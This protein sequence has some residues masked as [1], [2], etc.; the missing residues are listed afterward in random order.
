MFSNIFFLRFVFS[1]FSSSLPRL[2]IRY[3]ES[4]WVLLTFWCSSFGKKSIAILKVGWIPL[5]SVNRFTLPLWLSFYLYFNQLNGVR[6]H[7][8]H[9]HFTMLR[10]IHRD[11]K[12]I[13]NY[14]IETTVSESLR[15]ASLY[16]AYIAASK[17]Y[18]TWLY[19][20]IV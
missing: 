16:S 19:V 2:K 3:E 14:L 15:F 5:K 20:Y 8:A 13:A 1:F 17:R 18:K 10:G 4:M 9:M 11:G 7:N 6:S 12:N